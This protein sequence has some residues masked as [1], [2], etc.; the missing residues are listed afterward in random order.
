MPQQRS[1]PTL[2]PPNE[3]TVPALSSWRAVGIGHPKPPRRGC[4][5]DRGD[6]PVL[7]PLKRC[8]GL[9]LFGVAVSGLFQGDRMWGLATKKTHPTASFQSF[10]NANCILSALHHLIKPDTAPLSSKGFTGAL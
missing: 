5:H 4:G 9:R 7:L 1:A 2:T 6:H 8:G 10:Q 3:A